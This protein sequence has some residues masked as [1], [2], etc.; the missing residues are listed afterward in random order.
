MSKAKQPR[1]LAAT[2][3]R[4]H[5]QTV[6]GSVQKAG[7]VLEMIRGKKVE[8]ALA[9]LTFSRKRLAVETKKVLQSAIANA[10]NNHDLNVDALY[11]KEAFAGKTMVM[12][13]F[14]AR[15]RGRGARILKPFCN[16]TV[17]V[18][19]RDEQ[20]Q[21]NTKS[22]PAK[23]AAAKKA[24]AAKPTATESKQEAQA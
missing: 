11:V 5:L 19:E 12:K 16:I 18:A 2:E 4:A 1:R 3:A 24:A 7:L 20:P 14:H 22:A 15:A 21:V 8:T 9:D 17:V 13:R 6:K 10:E 23:P